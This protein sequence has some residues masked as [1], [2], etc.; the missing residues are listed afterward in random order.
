M[1]DRTGFARPVRLAVAGLGAVTRNIHLPAYARLD[2]RLEMVA[3]CDVDA[4]ARDML[5]Q[6]DPAIRIFEQF[7]EM[8]Q[9]T[10]PD[11]VAICTPPFLHHQ[12]CLQ[13]L[14][15]GCH[16]FC[17]KPMAESLAEADE[18]IAAASAAQRHVV[19]N[20]QFPYMRIHTAAK[21]YI[22]RPDFGRLLY[23]HATQTFRPTA[24][25]EAAWREKMARRLGFEF[26]VH[27][28]EL[29][30]FFF[31]EDPVKLLAHMPDPTQSKSDVLNIVSIEFPGG[32]AATILLDRLCKG[33]ERYLDLR[34]DGEFA[35]INTSIGG[36]L[37]IGAGLHTRG[38]QPYFAFHF[39]KGGKAVWQDG[40][41]SRVLAKDGINPFAHAT[42]VHLRNFIDALAQNKIPA[43][44]AY[45]HRKTLA[46]I[47]AAYDSA[48]SG[49]S[50]DLA[51]YLTAP[52]SQ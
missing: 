8:L 20:S 40:N 39:V 13:A 17:E 50:V 28:F 48:A 30:R 43:G 12:Q 24:Q 26:G 15:H 52:P 5:R 31:T 7:A 1:S 38:R 18:I 14:D 16:V 41:R 22:G 25:T 2:G 34:L 36:E 4:A 11:L 44:A 3:G 21:E 33:P 37:A 46:L 51:S 45:D 29:I 9:E 23:L 49:C 27:V 47:F 10:K 19:V 42:A 35:A 6:Q 32:R